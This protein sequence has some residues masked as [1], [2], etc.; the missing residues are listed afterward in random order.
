MHSGTGPQDASKNAAAIVDFYRLELE[1]SGFVHR[2]G[3]TLWRRTNLKFDV[4]KF[5]IIPRGRCQKWRVPFGS[6]GLNPSCLFPFLPRLGHLPTDGLQPDQGF[7]QVRLSLRRAVSQ[8]TV[9]ASNIWWAGDSPDISD[10]V[11]KDVLHVTRQEAFPF[12]CRFEDPEEVLR[13]FLNDED[14]IGREGA[15]EFGKK[16]SPRRLLYTGFTAIECGKWDVATSNL[17]A[18]HEKTMAI[19]PPVGESVRAE[20]LP[21]VDQGIA[22]AEQMRPW[23]E[24][25]PD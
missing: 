1:A 6:F 13:T 20:I 7:G 14:A 21:Y 23:S 24:P 11:L 15:W 2:K 8:R 4:L 9:K 16:G 22:C 5:D 17:R 19:S 3:T 10:I 25:L 12:F 18:C